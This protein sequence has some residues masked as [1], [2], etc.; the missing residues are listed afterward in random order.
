MNNIKTF[1][2]FNNQYIPSIVK[3]IMNIK[4]ITLNFFNH[5]KNFIIFACE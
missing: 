5:S 3:F 2:N 4:N 1:E